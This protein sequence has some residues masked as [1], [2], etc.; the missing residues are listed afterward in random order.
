MLTTK[1]WGVNRN[2]PPNIEPL[3]PAGLNSQIISI[4]RN[5]RGM[6]PGGD[7]RKNNVTMETFRLG[8]RQVEI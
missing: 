2:A 6:L 7:V 5:I 3:T 4:N 8:D 1:P